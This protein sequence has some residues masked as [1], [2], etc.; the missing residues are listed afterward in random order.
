MQRTILTDAIIIRRGRFGEFHKSLTLLTPSMG[1]VAATAYGAYK[2]QS[3]LRMA[4]EPFTHCA[5]QLYHNPVSHSFKVTELEA[6]ESFPRLQADLARIGAA[7]LWVEVVQ[8]SYAAGDLSGSLYALLLECLR[9]V[10]KADPRDAQYL[11]IQ[12]LWRFLALSGSQPDVEH[13]ESCGTSLGESAAGFYSPR[14]GSV[15]CEGCSAPEHLRLSAGARRYLAAGS[16]LPLAEAAALRLD[17]R[18]FH[19]LREALFGITRAV[20]EGDLATVRCL[21][22]AP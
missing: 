3:S 2:M 22:A 20:L 1:L 14:S 5:A 12:F 19:S 7:S 13:C 10:D 21:G 8:K 9:L 4:S 16:V 17:A 15:L 11:T 6:R 18:A